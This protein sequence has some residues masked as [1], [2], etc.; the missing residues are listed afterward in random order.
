MASSPSTAATPATPIPPL[1]NTFGA[2][3]IGTFVGLIQY[4]WTAHQGYR[5]FRL[6]QDDRWSLKVLVVT[7]LQV[8]HVGRSLLCINW[9][10][11]RAFETFHS[12]LCVHICYYY[13]TTNYFNPAALSKGI[14]SISLLGASTGAVIILTQA[15][16]LRRVYLIGRRYRAVV[17]FC[18]VLLLVEFAFSIAVTVVTFLHPTLHNSEQAWMNSTGVGLAAL[19]DTLLTAALTISLHQS[20]TGIKRTDSIIDLLILYAINTGLITGIFNLLSF[21]FAIAMPNN[22]IYGGLDIVAT[23]FYANSLLAVLNSR[24]SL[25]DLTDSVVGH[26]SINLSVLQR[27]TTSGERGA[28]TGTIDIKVTTETLTSDDLTKEGP[29]KESVELV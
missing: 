11:C 25:A 20:R 28:L 22:L 7:I 29:S 9:T 23:K 12:F 1:D 8:S 18:A 10:L 24:R 5:Y 13:L 2:L 21:V 17:A 6:Y 26:T 19:A 27:T 15:F 14:W 16:F 3:L 4:G